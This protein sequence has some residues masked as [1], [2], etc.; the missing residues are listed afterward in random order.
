[1]TG[2]HKSSTPK[3][4]NA[5]DSVL[6]AT[7]GSHKISHTDTFRS[8]GTASPP[9]GTVKVSTFNIRVDVLPL[10]VKDDEIFKN[11]D[12]LASTGWQQEE[13]VKQI[14]SIDQ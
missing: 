8:V 4:P 12:D 5:T 9:R 6:R 11:D 1:M 2:K 13:A 7:R 14:H 3:H 10:G